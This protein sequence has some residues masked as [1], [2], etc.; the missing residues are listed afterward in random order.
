[1]CGN[2]DPAMLVLENISKSLGRKRI[3]S[4]ISFE[5]REGSI[6][7]YLGPNGAGK[8]TT[9][10]IILGLFEQDRGSVMIAGLS[11]TV[12]SR[13][14]IGFLLEG[15]GLYNDL[16]V[17]ENIALYAGMYGLDLESTRD[18]IDNLLELFELNHV[19]SQRLS[20]F[21]R[22]MKRK[23]A[24]VRSIIHEPRLLILDEPFNGLDPDMQGLM[25]ESLLRLSREQDTT[26]FVSSHNLYEIDRIC[27]RI[28]II[29][30]GVL[31]VNDAT[32]D[33]KERYRREGMSL[34]DV[35]FSVTRGGG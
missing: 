30:D 15:D 27:D 34:E 26:I 5:V 21:S 11:P 31:K 14:R 9:I 20:T 13:R 23:T 2:L 12:A 10:R 8:T 1:M 28:A 25:R 24:F 22:G 19:R 6:F 35:Y 33:L 32:V 17:D 16:T 7:G 3:L 29:K 18:K 4:D